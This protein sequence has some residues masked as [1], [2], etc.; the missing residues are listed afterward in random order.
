LLL[1]A[2]LQRRG[3]ECSLCTLS[4]KPTQQWAKIPKDTGIMHFDLKA[5]NLLD[6]AAAMRF[7]YQLRRLRPHIIHIQD[8]YAAFL[9]VLTRGF[10]PVPLVITRHVLADDTSSA[11]SRLRSFLLRRAIGYA[12]DRGVAV[13]EAVKLPFSSQT[14]MK[15]DRIR[16]IYN[17]VVVDDKAVSRESLRAGFG[18][19]PDEFIVLMVGVMRPG[20]GH[21]VLID[22]LARI[23]ADRPSARLKLVGDGPLRCSLEELAS[24][25]GTA[26]EFLGER[27]DVRG[28]MAAS[29]IVVLPS[30]SEALPTVLL[31]AAAEGVPVVASKVGGIPEIVVDQETGLLVDP[32]NSA[33]L[34]R[35]ILDLVNDDEARS[36]L[37]AAA[38]A[39]ALK[40]FTIEQQGLE[41]LRLYKELTT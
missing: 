16:V 5:R 6:P 10:W 8:P 24:P 9:G 22:S 35:A 25:F 30:L 31:E 27:R 39:R 33:S 21:D 18:W 15:L 40:Q 41:T 23:A 11:R 19:Q 17:G 32:G 38:R 7:I 4:N 29:D 13:S 2:E 20:K 3:V 34:A 1:I 37:G 14:R 36:R 28:L 26:V 12:A